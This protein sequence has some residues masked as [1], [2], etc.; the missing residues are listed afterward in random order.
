[1]QVI[2]WAQQQAGDTLTYPVA[3]VWDDLD[4]ERSDPGRGR[5]LVW[6]VGIDGNDN[7]TEPLHAEEA[8]VQRRML[9]RRSAPVILGPGDRMPA[10]VLDPYNDATES[11][12]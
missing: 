9:V 11:R 5:G 1:M 6:L 7:T 2:D 8:E 4:A 3:L 12:R 10:G